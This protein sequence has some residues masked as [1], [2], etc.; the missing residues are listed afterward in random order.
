MAQNIVKMKR[1]ELNS[2]PVYEMKKGK[3]PE[4]FRVAGASIWLN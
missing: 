1:Y 3:A 2:P 4:L